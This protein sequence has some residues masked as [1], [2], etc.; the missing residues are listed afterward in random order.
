MPQQGDMADTFTE[1]RKRQL[2]RLGSAKPPDRRAA[3]ALAKSR[4]YQD[5]AD[6]PATLRAYATDLAN[7]KAWCERHGFVAMPAAPEVVGAYALPP[8]AAMARRGETH[9]VTTD[10]P[11]RRGSAADHSL[12]QDHR[13]RQIAGGD[14]PIW[15]V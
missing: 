14:S 9:R 6:A 13:G 1:A 4:A 8:C 5:A 12:Y 7:Y 15:G 10:P 2:A 11:H 3:I